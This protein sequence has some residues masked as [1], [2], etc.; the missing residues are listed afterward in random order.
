MQEITFLVDGRDGAVF[1]RRWNAD[2]TVPA[3]ARATIQIAHG[4]GEHSARYAR[5]G[6]AL[7]DAGYVVYAS[8]HRGH[9]ETAAANGQPLGHFGTDGWSS[10][11]DDMLRVGAYA[12]GETGDLPRVVFGH[13]MGSF[14]LQQ[15]L[16]DHSDTLAG[17]VLS[18]TSAVDG[19][20]A[21]LPAEGD[22]PMSLTAFNAPF[23]P[24]RTEFDWL[25][26]DPS[27]VDEYI[28][29]PWC[30]FGVDMGG[31][32]DMAADAARMADPEALRE[33]R[34]DFPLL[35]ISGLADPLAGGGVMV[36][37]VAQ[38]YRD[39]GLGRVTTRWYEDARHELLNET[40]RDEVTSDVVAWLD[41]VV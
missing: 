33:I 28:A 30:G 34:S 1:V 41:R 25:S 12:D 13:S 36:D 4:M 7:T 17:A 40:N 38:R 29:D 18:G 19:L 14:A 9:G 2:D 24:A 5:F 35:M 23:E 6:A 37:L 31:L 22:E 3:S 27:E 21:A 11:I 10:L 8:D 26:R 39:A 15:L 20:A 16:L 32:R